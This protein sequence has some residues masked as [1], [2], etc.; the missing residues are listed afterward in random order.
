MGRLVLMPSPCPREHPVHPRAKA[1]DT[2]FVAFQE[3]A[4]TPGTAERQRGNDRLDSV[5][6]RKRPLNAETIDCARLIIAVSIAA[7]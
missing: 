2:A 3:T 6:P 1:D 7:A 5:H 4:A